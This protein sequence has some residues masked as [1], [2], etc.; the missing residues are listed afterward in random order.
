MGWD[1]VWWET[2][3]SVRCGSTMNGIALTH[4]QS[5]LSECNNISVKG[6]CM[7]IWAYKSKT[8]ILFALCLH[9]EFRKDF[10]LF[11]IHLFKIH[12]YVWMCFLVNI[13]NYL[14]A[15]LWTILATEITTE[16]CRCWENELQLTLIHLTL[17]LVMHICASF[18]SDF[19][20]LLQWWVFVQSSCLHS[21]RQQ[22]FS[23][24]L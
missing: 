9:N 12:A 18:G 19:L 21:N 2:A 6:R 20:Q 10:Y 7:S 3:A 16:F 11:K 5:E 13:P 1:C 4:L 14:H 17:I 22:T 8:E 24:L 23:F 15:C